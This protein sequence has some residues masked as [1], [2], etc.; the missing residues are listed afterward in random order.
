GLVPFPS[1]ATRLR[2]TTA[3]P[4]G[5]A[6]QCPWTALTLFDKGS[7]HCRRGTPCHERCAPV[8][9]VLKRTIPCRMICGALTS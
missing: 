6:C 3:T 1:A 7:G 9:R 4:C 2:D 8:K 5:L